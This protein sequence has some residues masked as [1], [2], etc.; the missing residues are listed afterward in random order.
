[1]GIWI[2]CM[3]LNYAYQRFQPNARFVR[4]NY[5]KINNPFKDTIYSNL[6]YVKNRKQLL[7]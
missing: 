2:F 1:M 5:D 4:S 3:A 6:L 7:T